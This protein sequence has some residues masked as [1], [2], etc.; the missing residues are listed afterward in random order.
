MS[1]TVEE[2]K[3]K[4]QEDEIKAKA[5]KK[6]KEQR[7]KKFLREHGEELVEIEEPLICH[8]RA[9]TTKAKITRNELAQQQAFVYSK[10]NQKILMKLAPK[11]SK[12]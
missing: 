5:A 4:V 2:F 10:Y 6:R 9:T 8:G 1:Y 7:L 12:K 3:K 11:K